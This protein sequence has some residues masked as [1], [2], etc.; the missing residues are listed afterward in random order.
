MHSNAYV[1]IVAAVLHVIIICAK[2]L[3]INKYIA[4]LV[5]ISWTLENVAI[6]A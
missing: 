3:N 5:T 6:P 4:V 1:T 2:V